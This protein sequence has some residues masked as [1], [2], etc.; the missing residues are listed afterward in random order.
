M[1]SVR[2]LRWSRYRTNIAV[3]VASVFI[4]VAT[5]LPIFVGLVDARVHS[6][7]ILSSVA[8]GVIAALGTLLLVQLAG[9]PSGQPSA[10]AAPD[11]SK[12]TSDRGTAQIR[13][14][15][16]TGTWVV[17]AVFV[18]ALL[19]LLLQQAA[20]RQERAAQ[21]ADTWQEVS[22]DFL[23]VAANMHRIAGDVVQAGGDSDDDTKGQLQDWK[24]EAQARVAELSVVAPPIRDVTERLRAVSYRSA[25]V[26]LA[27]TPDMTLDWQAHDQEWRTACSEFL[28]AVTGMLDL[29]PSVAA[30]D[31]SPSTCKPA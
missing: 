16:I 18:S 27:P 24:E 14:A 12:T 31:P 19:T 6:L 4:A 22:G 15:H 20:W 5:L 25:D 13:S 10:K 21:W 30:A 23:K 17:G 29:D 1:S 11:A 26:V 9:A 2:R 7:S 3:A 28:S 8:G